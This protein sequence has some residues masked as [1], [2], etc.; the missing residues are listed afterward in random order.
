M[1]T[2]HALYSRK[3]SAKTVNNA[4][5]DP[6]N[7]K[8]KLPLWGRK[9]AQ[10]SNRAG[11]QRLFRPSK[12]ARTSS[13]QEPP[14]VRAVGIRNAPAGA[15]WAEEAGPAVLATSGLSLPAFFSPSAELFKTAQIHSKISG[16]EDSALP[17]RR[18]HSLSH[19]EIQRITRCCR[20][21][22][23]RCQFF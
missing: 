15:V 21:F 3:T 20:S 13:A 19:G 18:S 16:S 22:Y 4:K 9:V 6:C 14:A 1:L 10:S 11:K 23:T 2:F 8:G 5:S 12:T 7:S 17:S